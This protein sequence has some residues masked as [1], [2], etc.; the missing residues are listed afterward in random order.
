MEIVFDVEML[1]GKTLYHDNQYDNRRGRMAYSSD[2][3]QT[4]QGS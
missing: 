4:I 3:E 1:R 2:E